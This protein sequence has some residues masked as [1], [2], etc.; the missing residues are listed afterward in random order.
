MLA[1]L[2][3]KVYSRWVKGRKEWKFAYLSQSAITRLTLHV[4]T[5]L[6]SIK[7]VACQKS[8]PLYYI[9]IKVVFNPKIVFPFKTISLKNCTILIKSFVFW[10]QEPVTLDRIFHWLIINQPLSW[11]KA[12]CNK[13]NNFPPSGW[14]PMKS[15]LLCALTICLRLSIFLW[16]VGFLR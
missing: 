13:N 1:K 16:R 3:R 14:M 15:T 6:K 7:K 8:L 11:K 5:S 4:F 2:P 12:V 9:S 10:V